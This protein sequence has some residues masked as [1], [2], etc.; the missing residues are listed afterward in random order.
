MFLHYRK[1]KIAEYEILL[2]PYIDKKKKGTNKNALFLDPKDYEKMT[3]E[4]KAEKQ[5]AMDA[6]WSKNPIKI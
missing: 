4:E 1:R 3:D 5:K 6:H 2:S